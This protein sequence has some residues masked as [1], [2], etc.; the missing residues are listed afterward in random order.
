GPAFPAHAATS[1]AQ[2]EIVERLFGP[3][4]ARLA[5]RGALGAVR[6]VAGLAPKVPAKVLEQAERRL[7]ELVTMGAL[8]II[9]NIYANPAVSIPA[10]TVDGL[11]VGLQVLAPHHHDALRSDVALA[12][13]RNRP[14]PL[15]APP[16]T[17]SAPRRQAAPTPGWPHPVRRGGVAFLCRRAM[18]PACTG[19]T[20]APQR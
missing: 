19:P 12:V 2:P 18:V 10:G 11:P 17:A 20:A 6:A 16:I 14:S 1:N 9:S 5:V 7:P 3:G 4:P 8:T 15:R 13:G